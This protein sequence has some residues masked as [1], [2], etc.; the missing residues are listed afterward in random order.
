MPIVLVLFALVAFPLLAV[1]VVL[2]GVIV[3]VWK[4]IAFLA[5]LPA[6]LLAMTVVLSLLGGVC[7]V[8]AVTSW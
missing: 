6:W 5:E 2:F 7:L 4:L 8:M 3:G 1:I